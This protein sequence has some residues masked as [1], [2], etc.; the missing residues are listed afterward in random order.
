MPCKTT[1]S[2]GYHLSVANKKCVGIGGL[3]KFYEGAPSAGSL[4]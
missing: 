1:Y 3:R 2:I 4:A